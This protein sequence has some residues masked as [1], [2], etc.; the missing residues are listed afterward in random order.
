[1]T[2]LERFESKYLPV[3]ESGCWLW[4]EGQNGVGYGAFHIKRKAIGAHRAAWLLYRGSIPQGL[5]VLHRCDV[6]WCVNPKH[7]FLGT[8]ADNNADMVAKRRHPRGASHGKAKLTP[9]QVV[10][11]RNLRASG[12]TATELANR[13]NVS[14]PTIYAA[15]RGETW[16]E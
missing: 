2:L 4:T 11:I 9:V 10:E 7:L 1:M 15:A 8:N 3:T 5:Q 12:H 16:K 6:R 14:I 13:F